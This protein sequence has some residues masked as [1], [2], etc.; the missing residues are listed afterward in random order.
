MPPPH[1]DPAA[2][3]PA[4]P[5]RL[6]LVRRVA[7]FF[8][9][10]VAFVLWAIGCLF[11]VLTTGCALA[12]DAIEPGSEYG[13]CWTYALVKWIREGGYLVVRPADGVTFLWIFPV[14][15]VLHCTE[16]PRRGVVLTQTYPVD[17]KIAR[18]LPLFSVYFRHV[19]RNVESRHKAMSWRA[20][21]AAAPSLRD[22]SLAWRRRWLPFLAADQA[23]LQRHA[24]PPDDT[25]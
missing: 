25:A 18:L 2:T 8:F 1:H 19:V 15:H 10:V 17:R 6:R 22:T 13:N 14:L 16:L 24:P 21:V 12:A 7:H 23:P 3:A 20:F 5:W 9:A 4:P 11:F